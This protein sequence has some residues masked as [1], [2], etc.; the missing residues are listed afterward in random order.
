MLKYVIKRII[1]MIPVL[2]GVIVIVFTLMYVSPGDPAALKLGTEAT[3]EAIAQL[4]AEMGLDRPYLVQLGDYI[5]GVITRFDLGESYRTGA[6]VSAEIVGRIGIT[7]KLAFIS[8]AIG[9]VLGIA[10]GILS[11]VKQYSFI[12][13]IMTVFALFGISTPSFWLALMLILAFS[14]N[15]GWLPASGSYGLRYWILPCA[16]L[17]YQAAGI[18]MRMTRSSMLESIR[19][20][21]VTTARAKGQTEGKIIVRHVLRKALIPIITAIGN[22]FCYLLGGAVLVESVF[23][24]PGLGKYLVDGISNLDFPAVTSSVLVIALISVVVMLVLDILYSFVDPRIKATYQ[25]DALFKSRKKA[26][27]EGGEVAHDSKQ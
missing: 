11:A 1:S 5:L 12:D 6:E 21:F 7:L 8:M 18:I 22:Q 25:G 20:D 26:L 16:T 15:L 4:R 3:P 9:S 24:L 23:S 14:V 10:L 19:Q 17:G 27:K 13:K 2:L